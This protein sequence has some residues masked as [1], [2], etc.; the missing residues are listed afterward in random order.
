MLNHKYKLD[1]LFCG[2]LK[3]VILQSCYLYIMHKSFIMYY[4]ST[5]NYAATELNMNQSEQ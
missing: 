2:K 4:S 1:V 3:L 5:E